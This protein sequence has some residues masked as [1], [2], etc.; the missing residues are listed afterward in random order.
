MHLCVMPEG[1]GRQL[2]SLLTR[3]TDAEPT[4][5]D[6]PGSPPWLEP[7]VLTEVTFDFYQQC[8]KGDGRVFVSG[9]KDKE[10]LYFLSHQHENEFVLLF[11]RDGSYFARELVADEGPA[12][13]RL[14]GE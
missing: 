2:D 11:P 6:D 10:V 8:F 4:M 5:L 1:H 7:R 14:L 13:L 12:I 3:L 9:E